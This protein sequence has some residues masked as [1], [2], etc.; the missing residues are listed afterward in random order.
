MPGRARRIDVRGQLFK[1]AIGA[2]RI[3]I[4]NLNRLQNDV[5]RARGSSIQ[6]PYPI[7]SV[8]YYSCVTMLHPLNGLSARD[9]ESRE[10]PETIIDQ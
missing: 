1:F 8:P 4:F 3:G 9:K 5:A 10:N 6:F 2:R 7:L